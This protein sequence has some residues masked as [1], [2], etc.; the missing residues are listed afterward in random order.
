[1]NH[2]SMQREA[3]FKPQNFQ[4]PRE[5]LNH[6]FLKLSKPE[7][8]VQSKSK[9]DKSNS[10]QFPV[11]LVCIT[12]MA[13]AIITSSFLTSSGIIVLCEKYGNGIKYY[14]D[15]LVYLPDRVFCNPCFPVLIAMQRDMKLES[16]FCFLLH[17]SWKGTEHHVCLLPGKLR[18]VHWSFFF[19]SLLTAQHFWNQML[20]TF[21]DQAQ[22]AL[23]NKSSS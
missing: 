13:G 18:V 15:T 4:T 14:Q 21:L 16:K 11:L 17:H 23:G 7:K 19:F 20:F 6:D 1:M 22:V 5:S 3:F 8:K 12:L 9:C 10:P 2:P